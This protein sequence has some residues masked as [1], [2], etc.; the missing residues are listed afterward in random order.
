MIRTAIIN[1]TTG[2][3]ELVLNYDTPASN[4]PAGFGPNYIAVASDIV[5]V[6][7]TWN[8]TALVAP[9]P[10]PPPVP[11]SVTRRQYYMQAV[12]VGWF[13]QA[14]ALA[15]IQLGT[16]PPSV[17]TFVNTL[18]ANQQFAANMYLIGAATYE[19][20]NPLLIS[21]TTAGGITP[22]FM[23]SFFIAAALL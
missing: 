6:G 23:D 7:W 8:G 16:L 4:P 20:N 14:Q 2:I 19:R 9:P 10:P 12:V 13:T 3:V 5:N 11:P 22:A 1:T 21:L 18:P 17:V 15:L